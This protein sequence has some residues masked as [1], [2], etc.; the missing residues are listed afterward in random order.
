MASPA[1]AQ[2]G[3]NIEPAGVAATNIFASALV[4]GAGQAL[5]RR[6]IT[7]AIFAAV[8]VGAWWVVLD[9]RSE[10]HSLRTAYRD[11]AWDVAR[12]RPDPRVDGSFEYYERMIHWTRS[13]AFDSGAEPGLQPERA[14]DAFNGRQWRL[15]AEI[16]LGGDIDAPP[17]AAGYASA[18]DY[19]RSRAYD[20]TFEWD[21]TGRAPDQQRFADLIDR[22]D[23]ALR[24]SSVAVGAVIANH[25]L[26]AA[27]AYIN[28]RLE[29]K[30]LELAVTPHERAGSVGASLRLRI[31]P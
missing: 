6:W 22:S 10:G 12:A 4:P 17:T 13:G 24:R 30:T 29:R 23:G 31:I 25:V 11:L 9:Q 5:E 21:W 15:A 3:A 26:S 14:A 16:F 2:V 19:Y 20:E 1:T 27:E 28:Q 8:E 7:A 18:L